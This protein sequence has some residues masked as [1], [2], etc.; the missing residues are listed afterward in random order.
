MD[1]LSQIGID[2]IVRRALAEDVGAGDITTAA[3]VPAGK[4][5]IAKIIVK[6]PEMVLAGGGMIEPIFRATGTQPRLV[7]LAPDGARM[8]TG[9]LLGEFEGLLAGLLT[10][11]RVALNFVQLLSGIATMTRHFVDAVAQTRA[12]IVDT[13][14][15]HPGLRALEKYAVRIG[16]GHNHRFGLDSGI[17]IK[18]NHIAAAGS[19]AGAIQGARRLAPHSMRVEIECETLVQVEEARRA[20]ADAILL[21]NMTLAEIRAA[22]TTAGE[23]ILLE[24]SGGV[25]LDTV[26]SIAATGVD[27]I[28]VGALTHSARSMDISMRLEGA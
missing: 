11:E 20:G 4:R 22:R 9:D 2:A 23:D 8:K 14:K 1:A 15:T 28:S 25:S 6:E 12:R 19:V 18:E 7:Y 26:A 27:I 5:G 24:V 17:L 16:G 13:R 10:G 21:D 3:T